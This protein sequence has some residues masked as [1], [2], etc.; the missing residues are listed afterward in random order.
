MARTRNQGSKWIREDKRL[1][2]YA[3]DGFACAYCCASIE[4]GARLTLDHLLA[5]ELGGSNEETNLVTCCLSCNSRKQ[6]L[7]MRRWFAAL[8]DRGVDTDKIGSRIRH[9]TARKLDRKLGKALLAARKP[10]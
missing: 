1:A 3:R 8:R 5:C 7:T 10:R 6:D 2:L 4:D 9:L